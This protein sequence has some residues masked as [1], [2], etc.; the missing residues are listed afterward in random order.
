ML[1]RVT[2][3]PH[4]GDIS[5]F[6]LFSQVFVDQFQISFKNHAKLLITLQPKITV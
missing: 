3:I 6:I 4:C 2:Y 1:D 5:N